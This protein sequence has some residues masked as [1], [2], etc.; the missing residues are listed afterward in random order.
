MSFTTDLHMTM[1]SKSAVTPFVMCADDYGMTPEISAGI[2]KLADQNRISATS[3]MSLSPH[4]PHWAPPL[5]EL[6]GRVDAGLHLDWT[7][8]FAVD[9][10]FGKS[11]PLLMAL[12]ALRLLRTSAIECAIERQLDLFETHFLA[13]PD[14]VDGH[15]H[16]HQFP[17]IREVLMRV[18]SRRYGAHDR[19]WIRIARITEA[20]ASLKSQVINAMGATALKRLTIGYGFAHSDDLTGVYDF[21]GNAHFYSQRLRNWL[22]HMPSNSVLMCHPGQGPCGLAPFAQ[23]RLWEQ[24]V[25]QSEAFQTMLDNTQTTLVRGSALFQRPDKL[26]P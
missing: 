11:L 5:R 21:Q 16:I 14:H 25:L 18:L 17:V 8:A 22:E 24:E 9:E 7:S 2:L 20:A 6:R 10:G 3:V 4:W 26:T 19:P 23:A 12:S 13:P 1:P 15:Q